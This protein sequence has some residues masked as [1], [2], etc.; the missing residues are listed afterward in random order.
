SAQ[1]SRASSFIAETALRL[2]LKDGQDIAGRIL[3]PGYSRT[4]P[5]RN[6][7]FVC[8]VITLVVVFKGHPELA[9]IIHSF[10]NVTDGK[11]KNRER[12]RSMI[13]LGVDEDIISSR[14]NQM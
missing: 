8:F 4:P 5:T 3:K 11:I 13:G 12:C 14:D 2:T 1:R 7:F 9:Q 6:A 10:F